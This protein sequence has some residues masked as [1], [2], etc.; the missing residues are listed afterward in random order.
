[1]ARERVLSAKETEHHVRSV[2]ETQWADQENPVQKLREGA[3]G[4]SIHL[5]IAARQRHVAVL[6]SRPPNK[7]RP[8]PLW[9]RIEAQVT[10]V[11]T[12]PSKRRA[13]DATS[14]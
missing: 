8:V 14:M 3:R 5:V 1:M 4:L 7:K 11:Y 9:P 6:L 10:Q 13:L 12:V 2:Q